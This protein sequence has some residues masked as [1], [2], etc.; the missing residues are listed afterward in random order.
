MIF[1][2]CREAEERKAQKRMDEAVQHWSQT[3]RAM[4]LRLSFQEGNP[5]PEAQPK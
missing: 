2:T 5:E 1:C 4:F 3:L